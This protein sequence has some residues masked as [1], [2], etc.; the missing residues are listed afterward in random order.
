MSILL[1]W[2]TYPL[3]GGSENKADTNEKTTE[4]KA[5]AAPKK[6]PRRSKPAPVLDMGELDVTE[7]LKLAFKQLDIS[8]QNIVVREDAEEFCATIWRL[9]VNNRPGAPPCPN[10]FKPSNAAEE[11]YPVT[12]D[13]FEKRFLKIYGRAVRAEPDLIINTIK[14][15]IRELLSGVEE[16]VKKK[17]ER[18]ERVQAIERGEVQ[19]EEGARAQEEIA[20]SDDEEEEE[21]EDEDARIDKDGILKPQYPEDLPRPGTDPCKFHY[22]VYLQNLPP[23][24]S[25]HNVKV[26]VSGPPQ[27]VDGKP[28]RKVLCT[29][30]VVRGRSNPTFYSMIELQYQPGYEDDLLFTVVETLP[31]NETV[32]RGIIG[33]VSLVSSDLVVVPAG[34]KVVAGLRSPAP[35]MLTVLASA[36]TKLVLERLPLPP[37]PGLH[38][39]TVRIELSRLVPSPSQREFNEDLDVYN[40]NMEQSDLSTEERIQWQ[41]LSRLLEVVPPYQAVVY[42]V[43]NPK[44]QL[45]LSGPCAQDGEVFSVEVSLSHV[46]GQVQKLKLDL[47]QKP[48]G[49]PWETDGMSHEELKHYAEDRRRLLDEDLVGV[50]EVL[51]GD[52]LQAESKGKPLTTSLLHFIADQKAVL[53]NAD[54][55]ATF[56]L[57]N[58]VK[59]EAAGVPRPTAPSYLTETLLKHTYAFSVI[60]ADVPPIVPTRRP[61]IRIEFLAPETFEVVDNTEILP[62]DDK[63]IEEP[64]HRFKK[65][66]LFT[67]GPGQV[68]DSEMV[69]RV[70]DEEVELGRVLVPLHTLILDKGD[71]MQFPLQSPF[72]DRSKEL[73]LC[74]SAV[75]LARLRFNDPDLLPTYPDCLRLFSRP[76]IVHSFA[77]RAVP[78]EGTLWFK[79][80]K[81]DRE[82]A[83]QVENFGGTI[84]FTKQGR[85]LKPSNSS[86][87][88]LFSG[89]YDNPEA[90]MDVQVFPGFTNSNFPAS[91]TLS[92]DANLCLSIV[93]MLIS[94]EKKEYHLQLTN[95]ESRD[96]VLFVTRA[97]Q[98]VHTTNIENAKKALEGRSINVL[99]ALALT[100]QRADDDD[101]EEKVK[102]EKKKKEK[103]DAENWHENILNLYAEPAAPEEV[104]EEDPPA[105][106]T[107][108]DVQLR[109]EIALLIME[110]I[111]KTI[112]HQQQRAAQIGNNIR[113][114]DFEMTDK[115]EL[116]GQREVKSYAPPVFA[117]IRELYDVQD[118]D[119]LYGLCSEQ[120]GILGYVEN[121]ANKTWEMYSWE[122]Q[123]IIRS[124]TD[125]EFNV[126]RKMI[127][128]YYEYVVDQ[129]HTL[130]P[131]IFGLYR[132]KSSRN[133]LRFLIL[134]NPYFGPLPVHERF[135]IQGCFRDR[136]SSAFEAKE[137]S[138][139]LLK[140]VDLRESNQRLHLGPKRHRLAE[141]L[142][143]DAEFLASI[144]HIEY[145]LTV[146]VCYRDRL[147]RSRKPPR[148][149]YFGLRDG[150][151]RWQATAITNVIQQFSEYPEPPAPLPRDRRQTRF[152]VEMGGVH[153]LE[154]KDELER[155]STP[156]IN[157]VERHL[158]LKIRNLPQQGLLRPDP[159][160]VLTDST[161]KVIDQTEWVA[162]SLNPVFETPL[163]VVHQAGSGQVLKASVY[164]RANVLL[165]QRQITGER[166]DVNPIRKQD[167]LAEAFINLDD[168]MSRSGQE[169]EYPMDNLT[170]SKVG[171]AVRAAK[172]TLLVFN[173]QDEVLADYKVGRELY[174]V[175]INNIFTPWNAAKAAKYIGGIVPA[176]PNDIPVIPPPEYAKRF[177][178]VVGQY[179]E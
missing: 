131:K 146:G 128:P 110:G 92:A 37:P 114:S 47:Y 15:A 149:N 95:E 82:E 45:L 159:V 106:A 101:K 40:D 11:E 23:S 12:W 97:L 24:E 5:A 113:P 141:Q 148:Q 55:E 69:V 93:V 16:E 122:R 126:I 8:R 111:R 73:S 54:A 115:A 29:T 17:I 127:K 60:C 14:H 61:N 124:L 158:G 90:A 27:E 52:M 87:I 121:T 147:N 165:P 172:T 157:A 62:W 21:D 28:R 13:K 32:V 74:K 153:A 42:D 142:R 71:V 132:I 88:V 155:K 58:A 138:I 38:K 129:F 143:K 79:H 26:I 174:Y 139:P 57:T 134:R 25:A 177:T 65:P 96:T 68:A 130:L 178:Q 120:N 36:Q 43:T 150:E 112:V 86:I 99:T 6:M 119:F 176:D 20:S 166:V 136:K 163:E 105:R 59:I 22:R 84:Y 85:E 67:V 109:A 53:E 7:E 175:S 81:K 48:P 125:D 171:E 51:V 133:T 161:G 154:P 160:V 104:V 76:I 117:R 83:E 63:Y 137:Q 123:F 94:G 135:E 78:E 168:V 10:F 19:P 77:D 64:V 80:K 169:V 89:N 98:L 49:G 18:S 9:L 103:E 72:G 170:E 100:K 102:T 107:D 70:M 145:T 164:N 151:S 30:E 46:V 179:F 152:T 44:K 1:D 34:A 50:V 35:E 162:Q 66:V 41:E 75:Q 2:L 140:D 144:K 91:A 167:L 33:N 4:V 3:G 108:D 156:N 116:E 118:D 31:Y 39:L 56:R 173:K